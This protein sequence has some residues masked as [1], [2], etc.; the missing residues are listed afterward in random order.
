M[1]AANARPETMA[2]KKQ[3]SG[4]MSTAVVRPETTRKRSA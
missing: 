4:Y 2:R 1:Y 3:H